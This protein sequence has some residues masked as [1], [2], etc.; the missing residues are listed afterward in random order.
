MLVD[1]VEI[2]RT[3]HCDC[4][5]CL[6]VDNDSK[7]CGVHRMNRVTQAALEHKVPDLT[8]MGDYR[9]AIQQSMGVIACKKDSLQVRLELQIEYVAQVKSV[10]YLHVIRCYNAVAD[11]LTTEALGAKSGQVVEDPG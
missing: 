9:L 5:E 2:T 11:T 1:T 8:F 4:C 10:R 3:D 6:P 7:S